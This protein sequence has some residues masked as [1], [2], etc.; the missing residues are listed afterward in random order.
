MATDNAQNPL[1]P[2][3]HPLSIAAAMRSAAA[4]K[5]TSQMPRSIS[6]P[7]PIPPKYSDQH[8]QNSY[9][10]IETL[11]DAFQ[12]VPM[13]A[14]E[15]ADGRDDRNPGCRAEKIPDEKLAP[16]HAQNSGQRSGDKAY[17]EDE[18]REENGHRAELREEIFSALERC[19]WNSK[20]TKIAIEQWT[21]AVMSQR[22]AEAAAD[23]GHDCADKNDPG[24]VQFVLRKSEEA[25]QKKDG[26]SWQRQAD[27]FEQQCRADGP[28]TVV[29]DRIA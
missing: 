17:A 9:G 12:P 15:I 13:T 2:P 21:S 4:Q 11:E 19:R 28:I 3:R 8:D 1:N 6:Q 20:E 5:L 25:G 26:L 16:G 10:N 29:C 14:K 7:V 18:A 23:G 27:V 24:Q 22:E